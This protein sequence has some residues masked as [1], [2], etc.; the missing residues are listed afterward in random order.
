[1]TDIEY[2]RRASTIEKTEVLW[3]A[4]ADRL[5]QVAPD[6]TVVTTVPY[7]HVQRLRL[8]FA[9]GR[10][11]TERFL[12]ELRGASSRLVITNMH[13]VRIGQFENRAETFFPLVRQVV[14]GVHA[15]NPAAQFSAG[16]QP[17]LYWLMLGLNAAVFGL[18]AMIVLFLPIVPGNL[19]L[20]ALVKAG[21]LVFSLP[22][23]L[24]W[25]INAR[26]RRFDPSKE[27]EKVLSARSP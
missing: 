10:F 17:S 15:Q 9:P 3:R 23:L 14:A 18:L 24:S 22:M 27:L 8:A 5:E 26:P 12:M 6:G 16:E 1:M 11:Q 21:I 19:P 13:F 2:R 4:Q 25:A 7:R 20:S